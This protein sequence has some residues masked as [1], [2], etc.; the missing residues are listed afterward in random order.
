MPKPKLLTAAL[1][2]NE[3]SRER[4]KAKPPGAATK[5]GRLQL[6]REKGCEGA[7]EIFNDGAHRRLNYATPENQRPQ[8]G[9]W[10]KPHPAARQANLCAA[11]WGLPKLRQQCPGKAAQLPQQPVESPESAGAAY[12]K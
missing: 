7:R 11:G 1:L 10:R 12:Q 4:M 6:T 2:R 3:N 8:V 9:K 5:A